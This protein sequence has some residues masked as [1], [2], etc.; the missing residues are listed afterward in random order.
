MDG[1]DP[2]APLV[3]LG[4]VVLT[5]D[6]M[7]HV[8]SSRAELI[9]KHL[10]V[11]LLDGR[12]GQTPA[13]TTNRKRTAALDGSLA[14]AELRRESTVDI[15]VGDG[16]NGDTN[17][18]NQVEGRIL[19]GSWGGGGTVIRG[20]RCTQCN[21]DLV[22]NVGDILSAKALGVDAALHF[23]GAA[24]LEDVSVVGSP[25]LKN[26]E[27]ALLSVSI[28][29]PSGAI[30]QKLEIGVKSKAKDL[31]RRSSNAPVLVSLSSYS[32]HARGSV[33]ERIHAAVDLAGGK[34]EKAW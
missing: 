33:Q 1:R 21:G 19:E 10:V 27:P 32:V 12:E 20:S 6:Q 9:R 2:A 30:E 8:L 22:A 11:L 14:R 4:V 25:V 29:D 24:Q 31:R 17:V 3:G 34:L 23:D 28:E 5:T 13:E 18:R 16:E 7:D 15:G 26:G